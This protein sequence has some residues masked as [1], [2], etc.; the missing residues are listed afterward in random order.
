VKFLDWPNHLSRCSR[1][2]ADRW[3]EP[4]TT[5]KEET[6]M[7][8]ADSPSSPQ[9]PRGLDRRTLL[10]AGLGALGLNAV[11]AFA[12]S[13]FPDRHI[14]LV[15]PFPG[16][17][18]FDAVLRA[19]GNAAAQDL[20]QPI[21]LNHKPGAGGVSG[22]AGLAMMNEA[23]GYTLSVMHNSVIRHPHIT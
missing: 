11:P 7:P 8:I 12:A 23:D 10:A 14:T 9:G 19:M 15:L 18:M 20:G 21:V 3:N 4:D 1:L 5:P 16:G 22:T 6:D 13:P 17:G 2:A